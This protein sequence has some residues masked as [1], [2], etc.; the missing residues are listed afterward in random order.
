MSELTQKQMSFLDHLEELRWTL[1]WIVIATAAGTV[2]AWYFSSDLLNLLNRDL[3]GILRA[4]LGEEQ[5]YELHVFEVAEAFTTRLKV[6]LL[7][8]FL[9]ALP[10]N[11]YKVWQF[12]SPGLF[13]REK[14]AAGPLVLL[15]IVLFY[16][17]VLFAYM[18]MVKLS[19]AFL[20]RLKPP[21]VIATLRMGSY[22]SFVTKFCITFGV[23]FQL[24]LVLAVL[25]WLGLISS[26][27]IKKG[28][29]YAV[30]GIL[31]VAAVLTPPDIISQVLLTVPVLA[32]YWVGY[33]L[34]RAFEKRR[35]PDADPEPGR[36]AEID[37]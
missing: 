7:V 30:V 37:T 36:G 6:S 32:L 1:V 14:R 16:C 18:I 26:E 2:V 5:A 19:V 23:V 11:I 35:L 31:V 22:V 15:S 4:V 9:I 21:D 13:R 28:W 8:G 3:N 12:V 25:S 27:S 24:P 34:A 29:R 10:F 20:F 17:G 33:L